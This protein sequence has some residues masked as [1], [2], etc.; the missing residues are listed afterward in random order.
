MYL[1]KKLEC[2]LP[3]TGQEN[4]RNEIPET[5]YHYTTQDGLLGILKDQSLWATHILYLND[6]MEMRHTADIF[7]HALHDR[8]KASDKND[9]E[10]RI[11]R[12][13]VEFLELDGDTPVG[14]E[15]SAYVVSFTA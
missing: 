9:P 7:K 13:L 2:A 10:R 4:S 15:V 11:C 1:L 6:S 14:S 12:W 3:M 8:T 5:L